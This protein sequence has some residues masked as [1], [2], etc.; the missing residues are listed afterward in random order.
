MHYPSPSRASDAPPR[1]LLS[2]LDGDAKASVVSERR[3][4]AAALRA[5]G[6]KKEQ[7][8]AMVARESEGMEIEC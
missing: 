7:R 8:S 1:A 4:K 6:V 5:E 3:G 2:C